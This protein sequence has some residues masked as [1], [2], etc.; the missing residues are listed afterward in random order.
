MS[1]LIHWRA[2]TRQSSQGTGGAA[3]VSPAELPAWVSDR[4]A[5][6][7]IWLEVTRAGIQVGGISQ[8]PATRRRIWWAEGSAT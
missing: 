2:R 4:F 3:A 1:D 5:R 6:G 7:W 8:D